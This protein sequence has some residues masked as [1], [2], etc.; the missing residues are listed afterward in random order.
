MYVIRICLLLFL[1]LLIYIHN[2]FIIK[3]NNND[4]EIYLCYSYSIYEY[5]VQVY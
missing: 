4:L 2:I 1:L 3:T 5:I